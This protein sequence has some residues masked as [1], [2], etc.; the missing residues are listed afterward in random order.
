M[1]TEQ[2]TEAIPPV[3]GSPV[4]EFGRDIPEYMSNRELLEEMVTT[5]RR[6]E[7]NIA[8]FIEAMNNNPMLKMMSGRLGQ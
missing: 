2:P 4:D 6:A 7:R 8:Q 5:M 3:T 1:Q